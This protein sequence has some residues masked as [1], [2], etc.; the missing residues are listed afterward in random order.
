MTWYILR[1]ATRREKAAELH[2]I[3]AGFIAYCPKTIRWERI[4]RNKMRDKRTHALFP[5]YLFAEIPAGRFAEVEATDGVSGVL[6]YTTSANELRPR[7]VPRSLVDAIQCAEADGD[8]DKTRQ[9][10]PIL[11]LG[12]KVRVTSG[13]FEHLIGAITA[14]RGQHRVKVLMDAIQRGAP[15]KPVVIDLEKLEAVA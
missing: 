6:R 7:E 1:S 8:F 4:G 12:T 14:E 3:E 10:T 9:G 2:L 15:V 11:A 5:G 13:P